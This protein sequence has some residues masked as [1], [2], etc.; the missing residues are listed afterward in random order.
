[1]I[2]PAKPPM[3][4]RRIHLNIRGIVQGVGFRPF[5]HRLTER[6]ALSGW[7][8]NTSAGVELELEGED[9]R[10]EQFVSALRSEQP[11]LAV[12]AGVERTDL[13][14]LAGY[15]GFRILES[16]VLAHRQALVSPDVSTCP[17]CLKELYD[18]A[19]RRYRYPFLN[20]TNCGPRFTI[21]RDMPYDRPRTSMGSFPMCGPCEAEYGDIV[22]RRYHAQPTCCPDCGPALHWMNGAGER[23]DDAPLAAAKAALRRGEIVAIKGLGGFHLACLP[24]S[25][26]VARLRARKHRDEK[27]FALMCAD[28]DAARKLCEISPEEEELLTGWRRPIV[29]LR[30]KAA[31]PAGISDNRDLGLMLPYTPLHYLLME[32]FPALI[33]T[34]ANLSDDPVIIDNEQAVARLQ[35]IADG[36]LLHNRDITTRCDDSLLRVFRGKDYPIRRSRGYAPQPLILDRP[37]ANI[38]ACGAEQKAS[39]CLSRGDQVFPAQHIGDLK[40]IATLTHYEGQITHFEKLFD[41]QPQTLVCDLHPDYLSTRYAQERARRDGI[42]LLQVQHHHAHM[43]SCMA[44][45]GLEGD[46][47]GLIWDGTGYGSDGTVWGGECLVGGAKAF[48][49][50]GSLRPIP[51]PGG[52]LCTKDIGRVTQSLLWDAGLPMAED[53]GMLRR[54]LEAGL[55]CP[56]SS[57]MGRLFDGVYALLTGRTRV[58]YEGQGAILLEAMVEETKLQLPTVFYEEGGV[59]RF[60]HRALTAALLEGKR[61]GIPAGEL[62]AAFMNALVSAGVTQCRRAQE[63]TGCDRVVLSGGVFQNMYLL[64]RLLDALQAEGFTPYHHSRVSANDEGIAL[65]QLVI[66]DALLRKEAP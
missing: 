55:N 58:T 49:R 14:A 37:V 50:I 65:G 27:P 31:V 41:I 13:P 21:I 20:C 23:C 34:S 24:E 64:P 36:F 56:L 28:M 61:A 2:L 18:T 11:P 53:A 4:K 66:A 46:C 43:V 17:D 42:P 63:L 29:L 3:A 12:I 6:Y 39:F 40:N 52:D 62:A 16:E 30:K 59:L 32:D 45:N 19:N 54:Q 7:V 44:D 26:T 33:M 9:T 57:G 22:D 15:E 25:E 1:L 60:D 5:L 35:G 47:I 51:L 10:L 38:L 48:R 8:R